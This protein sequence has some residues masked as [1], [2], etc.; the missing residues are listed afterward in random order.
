MN[1][2][3][4]HHMNIN[5]R[6]FDESMK[7]YNEVLGWA[8]TRS[9]D[10]NPDFFVTYLRIPG[11]GELELMDRK[12]KQHDTPPD[13]FSLGLTHF[14]VTVDDPVPFY[15]LMQKHGYTVDLPPTHINECRHY[16]CIVRDP[17][18]VMLEFITPY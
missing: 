17:N 14:A 16:A 4:M 10:T 7:F 13:D 5:V 2:L 8:V 18:G 3:G 9:I 6:D 12:G 11:S 1:V 15:E